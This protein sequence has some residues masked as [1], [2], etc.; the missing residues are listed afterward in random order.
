MNKL[1]VFGGLLF[2]ACT[3]FSVTS[4][5]DYAAVLN[6]SV[7]NSE[8]KYLLQDGTVSGLCGEI[9]QA[10]KRELAGSNIQVEIPAHT[11]P[12]KRIL[13]DL[14]SGKS[15]L[16]CGAGRNAKREAEYIYSIRPVYDVSNIMVTHKDHDFNPTSFADIRERGFEVGAFLGTTS[17]EFL[18]M[19]SGLLVNDNFTDLKEAQVVYAYSITMIWDCYI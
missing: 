19:Q 4:F 7:Q 16:F 17:A 1:K 6:V 18:K 5:A 13:T 8:P 11:K 3:H 2:A 15:D 12:I 9:Y 14:K 10:L